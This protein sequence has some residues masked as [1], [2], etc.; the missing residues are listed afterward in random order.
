MDDG[1]S[2]T[3]KGYHDDDWNWLGGSWADKDADG[4]IIRSGSNSS[5]DIMTDGVK[6]GYTDTGSYRE[7]D[8]GSS[9]SWS[10]STNGDMTG[11]TEVRGTYNSEGTLVGTTYTYG[12]DWTLEGAKADT[13]NLQTLDLSTLD[14]AVVTALFGSADAVIKYST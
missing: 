7:G 1:G 8:E 11:G 5:V 9:Y 13:S 14:A 10:Y 3:N 2:N 12:A 4:A 6:T